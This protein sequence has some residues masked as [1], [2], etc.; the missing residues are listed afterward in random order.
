MIDHLYQQKLLANQTFLLGS[1]GNP[2]FA[3]LAE[4]HLDGVAADGADVES[5]D[6]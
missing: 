4:Q 3:L 2:E 1:H 5:G 6:V